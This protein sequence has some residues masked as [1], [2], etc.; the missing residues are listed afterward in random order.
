MLSIAGCHDQAVRQY[1]RTLEMDPGFA[2]THW[3][4]GLA[5]EEQG[6]YERASAAFDR[7]LGLEDSTAYRAALG[8]AYAVSGRRAD[9]LHMLTLLNGIASREYVSRFDLALIHPRWARRTRPCRCSRGRTRSA[10]RRFPT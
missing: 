7:A 6:Q 9:P 3:Y 5:W 8:H 1:Q 2:V 4:L 10:R